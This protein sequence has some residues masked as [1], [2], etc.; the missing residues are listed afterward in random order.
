MICL[1]IVSA[2]TPECSNGEASETQSGHHSCRMRDNDRRI[3]ERPIHVPMAL[4]E[5]VTI[6]SSDRS[7][8]RLGC[9]HPKGARRALP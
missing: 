9:A 1:A 8:G 3:D 2:S 5:D 6:R 7:A 4:L